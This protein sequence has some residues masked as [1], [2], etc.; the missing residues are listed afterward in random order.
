MT[1]VTAR[2]TTRP[3]KHFTG[4]VVEPDHPA[5]NDLRTVFNGMIDRRPAAILRCASA[6]DV[7]AGIRYARSAGLNISVRAGGHGVTGDA[8]HDDAIC[9]DLRLINDIY[10]DPVARHAHV[11]AGVTWGALDAA[12]QEHGLAVTGGRVRGT[13]VAGLTLGS[14]SGWLERHLGLTCDSL[15]AVQIVTAEGHILV[16]SENEH[17][18]LFWA[19][20]GGGGNF[21]VVTKFEFELHPLGP[22][23]FGGMVLHPPIGTVELVRFFR[24]FMHDAPPEVGAGMAFISAPDAPFVPEFARGKPAVGMVMCY[25]GDPATGEQVLRPL[26]EYGPPVRD[27]VGTLN[28]T[29]LQGLLE[30]G[31]TH[32]RLNYWKADFLGELPDEAVDT[33]VQHTSRVTSPLS[34]TIL[35][36]LGGRVAEIPEDA[37]AFGQRR[38][39][40]NMHILSMWDDPADSDRHIQ[41]T[42]DFHAA[43]RA[44]ATGGAYLNFVGHE[45]QGQVRAAF[46]D[47]KYERLR[48]IK[49]IYDPENV[50]HLNQNIPP[51]EHTPSPNGTAE[52]R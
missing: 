44:H 45:G 34:Q 49:A 5:Y 6:D 4:E 52:H 27:M 25:A 1:S 13:G 15:R 22:A 32:G 36:P 29:D 42:R 19:V 33:L 23:I 7:V 21:G 3:I 38:A 47:A 40:F 26:R 35:M 12:T 18:D 14:G 50:F 8:V 39:A 41:W 16:A 24:D 28:Y 9:L 2:P 43:M 20:R 17:P 10:V 51:A 48:Q 11:G 31:N 46:G 37:M 30:V